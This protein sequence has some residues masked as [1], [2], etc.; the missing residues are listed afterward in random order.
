MSYSAGLS[1]FN[2]YETSVLKYTLSRINEVHCRFTYISGI[3]K[4]FIP[5]CC[6]GSYAPLNKVFAFDGLQLVSFKKGLE[7][8]K[9]LFLWIFA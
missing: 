1:F 9:L 5:R 2:S 3:I 4:M 8:S 7:I 6:T